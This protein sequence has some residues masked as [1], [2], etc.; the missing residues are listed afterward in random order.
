M[1]DSARAHLIFSF[2]KVLRPLIKILIRAGVTYDEF[3]EVIKGAYVETAVRDGIGMARPDV[4]RARV[5]T[6]TGVPPG[7]CGPVRR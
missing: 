3:R 6:Y 5:A 4:T 2:R 7:G 1:A